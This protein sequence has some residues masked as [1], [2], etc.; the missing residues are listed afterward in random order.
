V[1]KKNIRE[2]STSHAPKARTSVSA[3]SQF[4]VS[5]KNSQ[6]QAYVYYSG[7]QRAYMAAPISVADVNAMSIKLV[8]GCLSS[9]RLGNIMWLAMGN[10]IWLATADWKS[11]ACAG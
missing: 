3:A 9:V 8:M 10:V 5:R 2:A 1:Y 7:V 6:Y 11:L 4:G